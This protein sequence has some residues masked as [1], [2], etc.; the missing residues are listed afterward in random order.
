ME[1]ADYPFD[2]DIGMQ[3]HKMGAASIT[4]SFRTA[5]VGF[6]WPAITAER[7]LVTS[8]FG[9]TAHFSD[10]T[11]GE[12][13][14]V[15]LCTGYQHKYPFL[16]SELSLFSIIVLYPANLFKGV[17]WQRRQDALPDHNSEADFQ[18]DYLRELIAASEEFS[19]S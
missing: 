17:V 4:F 18:P 10:G 19:A 14:A 6:D 16:P 2:E 1:F 12:F 13:D 11:P 5:P 15:V 9:S 7:P 3:A 8:F